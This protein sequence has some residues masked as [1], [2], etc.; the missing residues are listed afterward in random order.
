LVLKKNVAE[1]HQHAITNHQRQHFTKSHPLVIAE[2]LAM[3]FPSFLSNLVRIKN[4]SVRC[5]TRKMRVSP[6][7]TLSL[8][9]VAPKS[10][11]TLV[12]PHAIAN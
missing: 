2:L 5:S 4:L 7:E 3:K 11:S 8:S 6:T 10:T 12:T 1:A 9:E